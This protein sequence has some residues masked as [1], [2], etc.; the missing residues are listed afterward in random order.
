MGKK[1]KRKYLIETSAVP[2][3]LGE[4]TRSHC[5][6]FAEAIADGTCW[7]SI[8][9]RKEFIQVWIRQC[10]RMA[11]CVDHFEDVASAQYYLE[12]D[13]GRGAK[14]GLHTLARFLQENDK[15]ENV[16]AFAKELAHLAVVTLRRFDRQFQRTNNSCAC[17]IGG[18]ELKVDFNRLFEDLRRFLDSI[19]VVED[20]PINSF[21]GLNKSGR[22]TRL[23]GQ[24]DVQKTISG[25]HLAKLCDAGR[26]ITCRECQT[27]GDAV[28][29]LDQP[30]SW[31]LVHIDK[32]FCILCKAANREQKLLP[33]LRAVEK[34][35]PKL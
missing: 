21:L 13:Y 2:A 24:P 6:H 30:P 17:R 32:D 8:Y 7:T 3:A 1:K 20:C 23:L 28:I 10:I 29:V 22:A 18:S 4:S 26:H 25:K 14:T 12:Q 35:A 34:D 16:K 15:I 27:I 11:F 33:S 31:C 19:D 9:I 5:Q